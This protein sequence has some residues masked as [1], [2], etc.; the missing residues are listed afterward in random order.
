MK[1]WIKWAGGKT[2]F[3]DQILATFPEQF[4]TYREPFLVGL[5]GLRCSRARLC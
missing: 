1:P 4:N 5:C 2:R 3:V